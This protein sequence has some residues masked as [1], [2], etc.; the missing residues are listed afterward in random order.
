MDR[1][2]AQGLVLSDWGPHGG[3]LG[4]PGDPM[5]VDRGALEPLWVDRFAAQGLVLSDWGAHGG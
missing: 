2:A 4:C 1:F 5:G 3:R